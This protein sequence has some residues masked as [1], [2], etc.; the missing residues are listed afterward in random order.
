[1][2]MVTSLLNLW[3]CCL[4]EI[5]FHAAPDK[6]LILLLTHCIV[7]EAWDYGSFHAVTFHDPH[8]IHLFLNPSHMTPS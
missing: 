2:T 8:W 4:W 3:R 6:P 1:M 5:H 7:M